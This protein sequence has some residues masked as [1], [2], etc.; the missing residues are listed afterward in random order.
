MKMFGTIKWFKKNKG[1][2]Y[3]IGSDDDTYFFE[4]IDC[5]NLKE[6]FNQG[7]KVLFVPNFGE[8]TYATAVEKV[9]VTNE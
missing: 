1:Y 7:D 9:V 3:I 6:T 8:F 2:G 4:K 5:I